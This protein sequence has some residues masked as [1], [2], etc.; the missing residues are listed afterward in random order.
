MGVRGPEPS[1]PP[2][3]SELERLWRDGVSIERIAEVYR[4]SCRRVTA[5]AAEYGLASRVRIPTAP[6]R[7]GRL[8]E[9]RRLWASPRVTINEIA[10]RFDCNKTRVRQ[11]GLDYRLGPKAVP[12]EDAPRPGDPSPLEIASAASKIKREHMRK[13]RL[14]LLDESETKQFFSK[15]DDQ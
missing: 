8:E 12:D 7:S 11:W 5:W 6:H 3:R 4:V 15:E 10:R 9:L 1:P 14:G 2:P 13:K